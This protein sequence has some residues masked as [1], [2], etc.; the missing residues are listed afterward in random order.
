MSSFAIVSTD[1]KTNRNYLGQITSIETA[2]GATLASV[3][4]GAGRLGEAILS[5]ALDRWNGQHG[6]HMTLRDFEAAVTQQPGNLGGY[7][8]HG[9]SCSDGPSLGSLAITLVSGAG[10]AAGTLADA[11]TQDRPLGNSER[12]ALAQRLGDILVTLGQLAH[13]LDVP[14]PAIACGALVARSPLGTASG[15]NW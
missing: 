2:D 12:H 8:P 6:E 1:L 15:G 9:D 11:A 4:V 10:R 5:A 14:L 3:N 13:A 7:D